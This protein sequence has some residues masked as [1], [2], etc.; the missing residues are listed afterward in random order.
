MSQISVVNMLKPICGAVML[1]PHKNN[2][3]SNN[4]KVE[5]YN[6]R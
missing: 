4:N 3:N 1:K 6:G 5:Q 2:S